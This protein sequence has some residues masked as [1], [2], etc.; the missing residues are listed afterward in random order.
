MGILSP[1][2]DDKDRELCMLI[3]KKAPMRDIYSDEN[4]IFVCQVCKNFVGLPSQHK[5][6]QNIST[7]F[8]S[9]ELSTTAINS[10]LP[11]FVEIS[12][13]GFFYICVLCDS[14]MT[15]EYAITAHLE[16]KKH[17]KNLRNRDWV[18]QT[19]FEENRAGLA[20][21]H[22]HKQNIS[23]SFPSHELSTTAINSSLPEFVEI[24]QCG[25]FYICVLCDSKMTS[26]YA[27]TAHLEGKKHLKNRRNRDWVNQ[28][29]VF[30]V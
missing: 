23:T 10:S 8:P 6:E 1:F 3:N 12:Q 13:C 2:I 17:F 9:H 4:G 27:I 15:S 26:E 19:K 7:S 28:T 18:N 25:F 5:H 21:Q 16:G 11:E 29:L 14:K 22:K 24:S 20:A 30:E